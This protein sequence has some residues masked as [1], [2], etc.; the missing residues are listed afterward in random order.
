MIHLSVYN[1]YNTCIYPTMD[2]TQLVS[3]GHGNY[4]KL[5]QSRAS[6]SRVTTTDYSRQ[7]FT[8]SYQIDSV[9]P[10][11]RKRETNVSVT[12][13]LIVRVRSAI[14]SNRLFARSDRET[15]VVTRDSGAGEILA[16]RVT[17]NRHGSR[18]RERFEF[19][20]TKRHSTRVFTFFS[21]LR[22]TSSRRDSLTIQTVE[23]GSS[24]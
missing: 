22:F 2:R 5:E 16:K 7:R 20:P 19:G 6:E 11:G 9:R 13:N 8:G 17:Q 10:Y 3:S 15:D 4:G 12:R 21:F 24:I 18:S 23:S 1:Y 14:S